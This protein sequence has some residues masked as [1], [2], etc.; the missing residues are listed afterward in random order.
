MTFLWEYENIHSFLKKV[1]YHKTCR[2][3]FISNCVHKQSAARVTYTNTR[4]SAFSRLLSYIDSDILL[5]ETSKKLNDVNNIY[6]FLTAEGFEEL[7]RLLSKI[8]YGSNIQIQIQE[9]R[10]LL[11]FAKDAVN[12]EIKSVALFLRQKIQQLR[13]QILMNP[14]IEAT[15]AGQTA[16]VSKELSEFNIILYTGSRDE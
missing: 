7:Y 4:V 15:H 10:Y 9:K 16:D 13:N 3:R 14:I 1:V 2:I 6:I 12:N 8:K 5:K 11:S